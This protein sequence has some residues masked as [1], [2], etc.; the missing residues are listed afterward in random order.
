MSKKPVKL[1]TAGELAFY[2]SKIE[3]GSY[4]GKNQ[5]AAVFATLDAA[6]ASLQKV[7]KALKAAR[8]VC[9]YCLNGVDSSNGVKF[10]RAVD[11]LH[12]ALR[13]AE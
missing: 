1:P 9:D 7:G 5:L 4:I 12:D 13:E 2:R 11:D 3:T 8:V 10:V 6:Q